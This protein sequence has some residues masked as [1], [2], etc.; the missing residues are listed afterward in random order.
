M[1]FKIIT[2]QRGKVYEDEF[3]VSNRN[4]LEATNELYEI[5]K[6]RMRN[7]VYEAHKRELE[8]VVEREWP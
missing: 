2:E 3:N 1:K 4:V 7:A 5:A 6:E 8:R